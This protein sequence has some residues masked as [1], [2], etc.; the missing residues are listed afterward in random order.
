M[1]ILF[2]QNGEKQTMQENTIL[3]YSKYQQAH[4]AIISK[5]ECKT[6]RVTKIL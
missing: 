2:I 1:C 5:R 6:H 3:A 4:T